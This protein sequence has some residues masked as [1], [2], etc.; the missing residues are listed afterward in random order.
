MQSLGL[1]RAVSTSATSTM[2]GPTLIR[3]HGGVCPSGVTRESDCAQHA[4]EGYRCGTRNC[5]PPFAVSPSVTIEDPGSHDSRS[6]S[7]RR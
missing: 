5:H 2:I 7:L 4:W 6:E 3:C 1:L